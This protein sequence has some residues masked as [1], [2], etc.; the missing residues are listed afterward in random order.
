MRRSGYFMTAV[1]QAEEFTG[2]EAEVL[3]VVNEGKFGN[4]P[5]CHAD[6]QNTKVVMVYRVEIVI[7]GERSSNVLQ[8][9]ILR[10]SFAHAGRY[11]TVD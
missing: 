11:L 10:I 3:A 5:I 2:N 6:C 1:Q 7:I 4:A 9:K 8:I